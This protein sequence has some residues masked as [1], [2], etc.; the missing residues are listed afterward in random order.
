[1]SRKHLLADDDSLGLEI[2]PIWGTTWP[3]F[4]VF[5]PMARLAH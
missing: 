2:A 4:G 3:D 1:V 5:Y